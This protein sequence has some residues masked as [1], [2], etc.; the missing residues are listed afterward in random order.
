VDD[1]T[2]GRLELLGFVLLMASAAVLL[3]TLGGALLVASSETQLPGVDELQR[4]SRGPVALL[5]LAAGIAGAGMLAGI[6][7]ILR[8][9][10]AQ[11]RERA[12]HRDSAAP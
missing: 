4:E 3:L 2:L 12:G 10:V 6:G 9:L 11:A 1:Q 5:L 7:G 8:L